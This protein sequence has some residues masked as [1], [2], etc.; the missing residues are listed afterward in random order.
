MAG[1]RSRPILGGGRMDA[2]GWGGA[3][4]TRVRVS[5][6]RWSVLAIISLMYMV[7]YI[8]RSNISVAAP[9]IAREL[10]LSKIEL[11]LVFSAFIWAY[12]IG[13]V[14]GGWLADRFGPRRVLLVLVVFWSVMTSVTAFAT[15]IVSLFV[16]RFVFG[17]GEAGAFPTASRAMQLWFPRSERGLVQGVT[18]C[19]SRFAVV[20][21]PAV[22][23][24]V[25]LWFGWRWIF[26]LSA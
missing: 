9:A 14:P 13:Q 5:R 12:A 3:G 18:H 20:I 25:M 19:L 7:T 10:S 2:P 17:L 4:E 6:V 23:V 11:G 26:H 15:G 8:D 24:Q 22:S 16:I 1:W 21:T